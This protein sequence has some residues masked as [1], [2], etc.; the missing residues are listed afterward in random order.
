MRRLR[1]VENNALAG[2]EG[3]WLGN[4]LTRRMMCQLGTR[5]T[6]QLR[7]AENNVLVGTEGERFND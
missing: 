1:L 4:A 7:L 3:E 5:L 2:A 6:R